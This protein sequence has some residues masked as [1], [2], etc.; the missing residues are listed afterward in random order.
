MLP[1]I[2]TLA[3]N[4]PVPSAPADGT[5]T[6]VSSM[7][8]APIGKTAITVKHDGGGIVLSEQGAGN[9]NGQQGT[10]KDTLTLDSALLVPTA[11]N[12]TADLNGRPVNM[13]LSFKD[14]D[15][16]ETGDV[17][18]K[19][20]D[21]A[22][23]AKHFVVLDLG[24]FSG[25]FALP[26]QM[27]AWNNAPAVA[28]VPAVGSGITIAPDATVKPDRPK[29]VPSNDAAINV[30]SPM[31]FTVWYDP[32]TMLVDVLAFPTQGVTVTRQP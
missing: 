5:Y 27:Q 6:Y 28:I 4:A 22:Q 32:A 15:A 20:Y 11:Y 19:T 3:L 14:G 12:A 29:N 9:Y 21:L 10:V 13:A 30:T 23:D 25:W 2:F 16:Y 8:G 26:A 18:Q 17:T 7:N 31:P 24:P 1:L